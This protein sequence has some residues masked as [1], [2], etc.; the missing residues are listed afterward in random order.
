MLTQYTE[1]SCSIVIIHYCLSICTIWCSKS[2]RLIVFDKILGYCNAGLVLA[3]YSVTH[4]CLHFRHGS[5]IISVIH[6]YCMPHHTSLGLPFILC[7]IASIITHPPQ[8]STSTPPHI[9]T[10]ILASSPIL[11]PDPQEDMWSSYGT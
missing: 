10:T 5:T 4:Y 8:S 9:L 2:F 11:R 1:C 7:C 3:G 6:Y